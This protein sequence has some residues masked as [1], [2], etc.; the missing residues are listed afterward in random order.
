VPQIADPVALRMQL[1]KS[2]QAAHKEC[3]LHP[4]QQSRRGLGLAHC[5]VGGFGFSR[6]GSGAIEAATVGPLV[7][8]AIDALVAS[9][10]MYA[11]GPWL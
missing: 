11:R 10:K 7:V 8:G 6:R 5:I 4:G 9:V 2:K 3:A 1:S